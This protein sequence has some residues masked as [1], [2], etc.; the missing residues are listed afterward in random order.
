MEVTEERHT[1]I[2]GSYQD[3][4]N[5]GLTA[6]TCEKYGYEVADDLG[7]TKCHVAN[8]RDPKTGQKVAQKIRHAGKRFAVQGRGKDMPLFG[9][10]L[11]REGG[12][13]VVITEGEIDTL[14]MAQAFNCKWPV[15]SLPNGAQSAI[16][17][18][19]NAWEWVTSFDKVVLCFDMDEPGRL[20]SEQVA[21]IL[22]PGKAFVM[23][24]PEG[25]KD[26]NEVLVK[27]GTAPLTQ[28]YWNAAPY[29]PDG[30]IS[31]GDLR[32]EVLNPVIS[33]S[34]PY[35][36]A[37]LNTRT[38]G[39]RQG[40]LVTVTAG[41]G[42]GKSTF[43]KEILFDL[44]VNHNQAVGLIFLEEQGVRTAE[45]LVGMRI[46]KNLVSSRDLAS[47][48]EI[49]EAYD[50]LAT[51]RISLYSHFGSNDVDTIC[52]KIRFMVQCEGC[53]YVFLDHLSIL[54]SDSE[55]DER[56]LID[57]TMTKLRTLVSELNFSLFVI[58]HL[59]RPQGDRGH[60]DGV[61]ITLGQLRGSHSIGHLSD[62]VIGIQ[63][64]P[65]D[66]T[67]DTAQ[68]VVL[69]NRLTGSRGDCGTLNYN[70][71]TGRLTESCF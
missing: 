54:V 71:V 37:Q 62:F 13:S 64:D 35:P 19:K 36:W 27:L 32:E 67:A 22:P 5:R 48:T 23:R 15:V 51:K 34:I 28:A 7:G 11:W 69:K 39:I 58:S 60:E 1:F 43:V 33:P 59:K 18:I 10:H 29:R 21:Q 70:R 42:L 52:N 50:F 63:K 6:A 9:S 44:A 46:N 24:L 41:T 12:K 16:T 53:R 26:A 17:A 66:P 68:V 56:K 25:Y 20:A 57:S 30:I 38:L 8:Y 55:G 49:A 14:S 61:A 45:A 3:I 2:V 47:P 31:F 40:E 65:S 4:P